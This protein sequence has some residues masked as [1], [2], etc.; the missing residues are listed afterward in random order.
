MLL[1][2]ALNGWF[3]FKANSL[4]AATRG[5]SVRICYEIYTL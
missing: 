4:Q 5:Q 2:V 3:L 1:R